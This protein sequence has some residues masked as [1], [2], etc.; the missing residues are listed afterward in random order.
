[1]KGDWGGVVILGRGLNNLGTDVPVE[2]IGNSNPRGRFGGTNNA[3]NSGSL[4]YA[5][6]EYAGF[7]IAVDN[8]LNGLTLGAVGSGT[9]SI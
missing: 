4:K 6:I 8:E 7:Q 2:G 1:L 5:R 3:D 9:I